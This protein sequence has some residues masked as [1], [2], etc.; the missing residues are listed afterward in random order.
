MDKRSRCLT[1][2]NF[3]Q[4]K[5]SHN[6]YSDVVST[7]RESEIWNPGIFSR[8]IGNPVLWNSEY[9]SKIRI[10]LSIGIQN[11]IQVP[12]TKNPVSITYT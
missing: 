8:G 7:V 1:G 5:V 9:R 10:P 12:L 2:E 4:I 3:D 6:S 11:M